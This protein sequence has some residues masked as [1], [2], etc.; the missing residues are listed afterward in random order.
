MYCV[1]EDKLINNIDLIRFNTIHFLYPNIYPNI[2][3]CNKKEFV[4]TLP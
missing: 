4:L 2:I 1:N 3:F